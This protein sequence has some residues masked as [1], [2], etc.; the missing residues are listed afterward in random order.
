MC[1]YDRFGFVLAEQPHPEAIFDPMWRS[2]HSPKPMDGWRFAYGC[3]ARC[4][5]AIGSMP[6]TRDPSDHPTECPDCGGPV[7]RLTPDEVED[8]P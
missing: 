7:K 5:D 2:I 1:D 4:P 3:V 6:A 8:W